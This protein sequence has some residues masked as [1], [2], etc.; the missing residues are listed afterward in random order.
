MP[1]TRVLLLLHEL[2]LTGAPKVILDGFDT[3][4]DQVDVQILPLRR[5]PLTERCRQIG[6]LIGPSKFMNFLAQTDPNDYSPGVSRNLW[7]FLKTFSR[8]SIALLERRIA[9]WQPDLI[10]VNS[11]AAL[12]ALQMVALPKVPVLLHVHELA[13]TIKASSH[14]CSH[15]LHQAPAR[16]V[17]VSEAVRSVLIDDY[18][19]DPGKIKVIHEFVPDDFG[20]QVE[21]TAQDVSS[22]V[23][24]VGGAGQ[25]NW[26]KGTLLWL[27]MAQELIRLRGP[28]RTRFVWVGV[29]DK[30]DGWE[31]R[32]SARKLGLEDQVKFVPVTPEPLP[33]FA[34]FDVFAMTSMEDPCPIVVLENMM[35]QKPV[36]C[37]A[38]GGGAPEEVGET[39]I[40]IDDFSPQAM[41]R[42]IAELAD[43]PER[44]AKMGQAARRRVQERFTASVQVPQLLA[45]INSLVRAEAKDR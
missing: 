8:P 5:G 31:F 35:L 37:F 9:S 10:Y 45:E 11:V 28:G 1:K 18:K 43:Q 21:Q 27:Q 38:G 33:H 36:A 40:V 17:A 39:G 19:I 16:Y 32:E 44:R 30:E 23:F 15:L 42:A 12:P 14:G 29:S 34:E 22:E 6:S 26:R 3:M 4:L 25:N 2:S 13:L 20:G 41:A 7:R 24:T